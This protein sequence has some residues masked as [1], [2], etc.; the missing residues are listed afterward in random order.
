M[1]T[2]RNN[3][4]GSLTHREDGRWMARVSHEGRRVTVYGRTKAEAQ[5]KLRALQRKQ[6][7]NLPLVTSRT[8]LKD[9]LAQWLESMAHQVRPKTLVDYK[10]SIRTHI[11][12]ELGQI[13]LGKLTPEHIDR[14]WGNLMKAGRSASVVEYAHRRL[15]KA[16]NDAM[17]R[18]LI[19]RNPCQAVS[20]PKVPRK[21][22][23][24][25]DTNAIRRFL[26]AAK[27]TEYYEALYTSFYTGLRRGELLALQWR[28][29][30]LTLGTIS[31]THSIYRAKGG[32][33]IIQD[34]KTAKGRRLVSLTPST[35]LLLRSLQ[36]RQQADGLLQG[37]PVAD[38]SPVFRYRNGS[39]FLP[40]GYSA[41]FTKIMRRAGLE[42][43]RLH[44]ARHAHA[45]LMLAQ[46]V[47]PKSFKSA[48][49]TPRLELPWTSTA[50]LYR[51][52]NRPLP[53]DLRRD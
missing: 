21:D 36:E 11:V 29:I 38:D 14:A 50:T 27:D 22:L 39:P 25:P 48:W 6:D 32:Q 37:Y 24:P 15:S 31:V 17:K 4:E 46:G 16:L 30:D 43:Y 47:H 10:V 2:R 26:D 45:S 53:F 3:G 28:D 8:L 49:A 40:R 52:S 12:P 23:Y 41:A 18:N 13:R 51:D 35:A 42:G 1:A 20:P 9:Y 33:S 34:P 5:Q 44:D 19:Y 7:E